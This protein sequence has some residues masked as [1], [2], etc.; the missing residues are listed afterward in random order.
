V[1]AGT[2]EMVRAPDTRARDRPGPG[3]PTES[4]ALRAGLSEHR[5]AILDAV[6]G[7]SAPDSEPAHVDVASALVGGVLD[8]FVGSPPAGAAAG[9][10]RDAL[11]AVGGGYAAC[12]VSLTHASYELHRTIIEMSR[13][14]WSSVSPRHIGELLELSQHLEEEVGAMRAALSEGYCAALAASGSR[15]LGR[16]QLVDTLLNGRPVTA[17]LLRAAGVQRTGHY[18]LLSTLDPPMSVLVDELAERFGVPD[19]LPR[20]TDGRLDVL[21]PVCAGDSPAQAAAA[22]FA[23]LA[24][25]TG[26]V[27]AGATVA[28]VDGLPAA[29]EEARMALRIAVACERRG[30]VLACEVL[31]ERAVGGSAAAV[32]EL[33]DLVGTM[34]HLP[35]LAP[36][37][38]TLYANDLDRGLT[39]SHLHIARRTLAKRLDRVHQLTGIHPTSARGV[40]TLLSALGATRLLE[41][42]REAETAGT[43]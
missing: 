14:W 3:D 25:M 35:Y 31:V 27:V 33:V 39:A 36:T 43:G 41:A 4:A 7:A 32:A 20:R 17:S 10:P 21:V 6:L 16:H 12:G 5:S 11:Y 13:R 24:A 9:A 37:L 26:V 1:S 42:D 18:L 15:A 38:T 29:A 2:N 8:R 28:P 23:R 30:P 19:V 22:A 34:A 40:Q